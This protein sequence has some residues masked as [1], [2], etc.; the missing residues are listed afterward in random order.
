M[1]QFAEDTAHA[2][3]MAHQKGD[4]KGNAHAHER[5]LEFGR[6][7]KSV[8][9]L[10]AGLFDTPLAIIKLY[11]GNQLAVK[12]TTGFSNETLLDDISFCQRKLIPGE[13]LLIPDAT[14]DAR[15]FLEAAVLNGP[16]LRFYVDMPLVSDGVVLGVMILS[17]RQ[18]RHDFTAQKLALFR[19]FANNAATTI[20]LAQNTVERNDIL[21]ELKSNQIRFDLAQ[22]MT[23]IGHWAIDLKTREVTWS[24]G[25][26]AIYGL[27]PKSYKPRVATQL[28][29]YE[30]ADQQLIIDKFQRAVNYGED[31]DFNVE[32]LRRKDKVNR[33]IRTKGGVEYDD[34]GT[35]IRLCGVV[36]DITEGVS[37]QEELIRARM[38]A[39]DINEA[40]NSFLTH[41]TN[42]LKTPLN[43]ILGYARLLNE[44]R[45]DNPDIAAYTTN[46]LKS[47]KAL[48]SLVKD[49]VDVSALDAVPARGDDHAHSAEESV[50]VVNLIKDIVNQFAPQAQSGQT[51]LT[52]HFVDL[53]NPYARLDSM[54][55][56]QVVQNLISNACKFT[57]G[58][59]INV[60]ASQVTIDNGQWLRI[61]VR[62]TGVGMSEDQSLSLFNGGD[63][64]GDVSGNRKSNNG[65]GLSISKAIVDLLGGHI[66]VVSRQGEGSNFWFEIPVQ[67]VEGPARAIESAQFIAPRPMRAPIDSLRS[68]GAVNEYVR[69]S[70]QAAARLA[71]VDEDRIN[72]EYLKALLQDMK[73]DL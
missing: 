57:R 47:A 37:D 24:K 73:L 67:W 68:N 10:A 44:Q 4:A 50:N 69:P 33:N 49:T 18:P 5:E 28:D 61:S 45:H 20:A 2:H 55:L 32:I 60:T 31:F 48:Q 43:N 25:L 64:G 59:L 46:L 6:I 27:S 23:G 58:G 3:A 70:S 53:D 51:K 8:C 38:N 29:I 12:G 65:L 34:K 36:R 16:K 63:I 42:E 17:E 19:Q 30:Q 39:E 21:F 15:Y 35:A 62:D 11:E 26:Y 9:E 52:A 22:D 14:A 71:P 54:R 1:S 7:C 40:K 66:G 41:I 13:S 56:R 72:R